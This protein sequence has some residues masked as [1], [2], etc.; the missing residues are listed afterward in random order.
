VASALTLEAERAAGD[1]GFERLRLEVSENN[2]AAR[3]LYRGCGY[4]DTALPP[5]R[6]QGTIML[7]S[8][9]IEVDDT[10]LAWEKLLPPRH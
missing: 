4:V 7:R 6:V 3:A 2:E 8:G 5:R 1:R 9:P 10:L